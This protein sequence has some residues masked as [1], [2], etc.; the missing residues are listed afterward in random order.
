M[1]FHLKRDLWYPESTQ[2]D[3]SLCSHF[4]VLNLKVIFSGWLYLKL[5]GLTSLANEWNVHKKR[6]VS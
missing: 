5:N 1:T 2:N 6:N 3:C 4:V